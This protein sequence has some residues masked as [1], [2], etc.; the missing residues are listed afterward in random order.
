VD[1]E[2]LLGEDGEVVAEDP[3]GFAG[4]PGLVDR[5]VCVPVVLEVVLTSRL[6]PS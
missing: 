1:P 3:D 6:P 2:P 5:S 4:A